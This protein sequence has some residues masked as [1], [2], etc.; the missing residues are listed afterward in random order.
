MRQRRYTCHAAIRDSLCCARKPSLSGLRTRSGKEVLL[1]AP[2]PLGT[3][4]APFRCIRLKHEPTHLLRHAVNLIGLEDTCTV[5]EP[6]QLPMCL[7]GGSRTSKDRYG[8][9]DVAALLPNAGWLSSHVRPH[10]REVCPLSGG[11]LSPAGSTP[12]RPITGRHSRAPPSFTRSPMGSPYGSLSLA[13]GLRAYH[14]PQLERPGWLRPRLCAGGSASAPGEFGAPGPD[15]MPFGPEPDSSAAP[16][17]ARLT[18]FCSS[19]VGSSFVTT[20]GGATPGLALPPHPGP[21]PPWCW[22]SPCRLTLSRP[23]PKG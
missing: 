15:H 4:R 2:P 20:L 1:P 13:G 6:S 11:V 5:R 17:R 18:P 9:A 23:S 8:P 7:G 22:Q 12:L 21:R 16:R 19:T 14:V 3:G 10:Q